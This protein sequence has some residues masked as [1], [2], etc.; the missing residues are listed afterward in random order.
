MATLLAIFML[1]AGAGCGQQPAPASS[2]QDTTYTIGDPT[3]DY[4]FPS[5]FAHYSRGPG[6]V[7]MSM[8]FDTLLWKDANGYVPA[9]ADSWEYLAA[10]NAYIFQLNNKALWHDNRKVTVDDVVFT[11]E[12]LKKYPYQTSNLSMI[13]SVQAA[14][15]NAVKISLSRVHAPFL[16]QV[17]GT[18]PILPQHIWQNV[19]DPAQFRQKEA[20]I[21]SGPFQL[22]DYNKEQGSYLYQPFASYYQGKPKFNQIKF[23]KMSTEMAAAA[24]KQKQIDM[25]QIPAELVK[26][27][28]QSGLKI[29]TMPHDWVAKLMINHQ[30]DPLASIEF[31]Q[32]LAC[33][34]DRQALIDTTLRGQGLK[35]S[36]GLLPFDNEWYNPALDNVYKY[37]PEA[38]A[39]LL[40]KLGYSKRG[41][42]WEKNGTI[43]EL[44]LLVSPGSGLAGSPGERQGEFVKSQLEQLGIKVNLRALEGKT[45]DSLI[46]DGKYDLAINGHGGLGSDPDYLTS[47]IT[48]KSF[49][50]AK[51]QTNDK[52]NKLLAQQASTMDKHLRKELFNQ[53]QSEFAN[54]VPALPLYYPTWYY[55]HSNKTTLFFTKQGLGSGAPIPLNKMSFVK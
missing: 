46:N 38:A 29:L 34:I 55:A 39:T 2:A 52:L 21:G 43:L 9:L 1:L 19:T 10:E 42:Y 24:L 33:A 30:K 32:A 13:K 16:D 27:L 12:Y 4:G 53:I 18:I 8:I 28:E 25:A 6:Y 17:A 45:L 47:I 20:L 3:G 7:R 11:F 44:E 40:S 26:P 5:P 50:S 31:R 35:G 37:S 15:N 41:S 51:Y 49:Q 48:G 14:G 54:A 36:P 22:A 23:V